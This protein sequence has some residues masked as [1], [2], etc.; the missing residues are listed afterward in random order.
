MDNLTDKW[1]AKELEMVGKII[2]EVTVF[3]IL[4][5]EFHWQDTCS[6]SVEMISWKVGLSGLKG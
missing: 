5:W 1:K 3:H 2:I 6:K 4:H